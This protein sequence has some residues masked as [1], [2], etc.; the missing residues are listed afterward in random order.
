MK[1]LTY[2]R[3]SS[4]GFMPREVSKNYLE[5][6]GWT[7]WRHFEGKPEYQTSIKAVMKE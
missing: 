2:G 1:V 3:G 4:C 7:M 5:N 6:E